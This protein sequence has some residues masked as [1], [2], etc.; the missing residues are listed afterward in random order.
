MQKDKLKVEEAA[1]DVDR[2]DRRYDKNGQ[3]DG[4]TRRKERVY[5]K[6]VT[7][8]N[9]YKCK[10]CAFRYDNISVEWQDA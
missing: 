9:F 3:Y 2:S 6:N 8:H 7:W 4:E 1:K 10:F 5:G